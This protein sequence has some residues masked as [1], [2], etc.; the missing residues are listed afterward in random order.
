MN[1]H[2]YKIAQILTYDSPL[3]SNNTVAH[4]FEAAAR[5]V[6]PRASLSRHC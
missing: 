4:D 3:F 2:L 1:W 5:A 6:P